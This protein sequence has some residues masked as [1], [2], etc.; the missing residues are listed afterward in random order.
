M[1]LIKVLGTGGEDLKEKLSYKI[2][3]PG[4]GEIFLDFGAK[5][6]FDFFMLFFRVDILSI[7]ELPPFEGP[8]CFIKGES[9]LREDFLDDFF[10]RAVKRWVISSKVRS[11]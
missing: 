2:F 7:A 10:A 8:L 1:I 9:G 4:S 3:N 11:G 5:K 6:G